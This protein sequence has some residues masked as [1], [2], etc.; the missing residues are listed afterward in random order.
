MFVAPTT[1]EACI[2]MDERS[3]LASALS[4]RYEIDH[5]IGRGGMATVY[6]ARDLRHERPVAVKLLNPE[7]G[8]VLGAERFL[9]EIRVTANLQHPHLLPLFDSGEADGLLFYVMPFVEG[10][11]LRALI[12]R[13]NQ[14][15][16]DDA[17]RI[18]VAVASALA[19]AHERGIIHRDLKPENILLQAGHP[20]VADFGIALA[21]SN[22]AGAR[23]TQTGLSLGTPSYMSPEQASGDRAI[24]ARSDIYALGAMTYE[25]IAG[26]PPHTGSSAQAVIA[27][28]MTAEPT[29]L[30]ELRKSVPNNVEAAVA[31]ALAK[32]PAD[33]FRTA[34]EFADALTN[35]AYGAAATTRAHV[36]DRTM[37]RWKIASATLGVVALASM[38]SLGIVIRGRSNAPSSDQPVTRYAIALDSGATFASSTYGRV[39]MTRD[40][41]VFAIASPLGGPLSLRRRDDLATTSL[42]GTEGAVAPFFS[43]DGSSV[44]FTSGLAIKAIPTGGGTVVTLTDSLDG[45][46]GASWAADGFIYAATRGVLTGLSRVSSKPGAGGVEVVT[47]LDSAAGESVHR[48]PVALKNGKGVLFLIVHS[49]KG[50]VSGSI[51][52]V[53]L[54]TRKHRELIPLGSQPRYADG[55]LFYVVRATVFAVP[56]DADA[57][58][59]TGE[60]VQVVADVR[61]SGLNVV[62]YAVS[63]NGVFAYTVGGGLGTLEPTWVSRDGTAQPVDP[64]WTGALMAPSISPDGTRLAV[65]VRP[66]QGRNEIVIKQLDRGPALK[67]TS[68]AIYSNA[69]AWTP[70]GRSIT[71]Q[72]NQDRTFDLW[73]RRADGSAPPTLAARTTAQSF[74]EALWSPDGKSLIGRT[75]LSAT[76]EGDIMISHPPQDT[77]M[78]PLI[79]TQSTEKNMTFSP[80]GKWM[81]Y[82][83]NES[84][85]F[86]VYVVPFPDVHASRTLLSSAGGNEPR[87]SHRG[88]EIF[89]RDKMGNMIAAE[90][91]TSAEFS[92]VKSTVLFPAAQYEGHN[93]YRNFDVSLDD[94]RFLMFRPLTQG[95][96]VQLVVVENWLKAT[97]RNPSR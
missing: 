71:Y 13:E 10:E 56:F 81:A 87:W 44:G 22:A 84:G 49:G 74:S 43:P 16:I 29:P 6:L 63:D 97:H 60:P 1:V 54:A 23:V 90:V 46:Y 92:A 48:F 89:Y 33:R 75:S 14:L 65:G 91:K 67:L 83:S 76:G 45:R 4:G 37:R 70:D 15:P 55:H 47:T 8:A 86:E 42:P 21:V 30:H 82:A 2:A 88:N 20:V 68:P 27:K 80:D 64:A 12:E 53:D 62:D 50:A 39:A 7:L 94:K 57:M 41:S 51:G 79:A 11:T 66:V 34:T 26:D 35:P 3:A 69:P 78:R 18:A 52:V 59:I 73:T 17:V 32:S 61:V 28:L 93:A 58:K 9:S 95:A 38:V 96:G 25:M 77:T 19:Y 5:E 31:K 72:S 36:P 40:G 85:Q 24:D